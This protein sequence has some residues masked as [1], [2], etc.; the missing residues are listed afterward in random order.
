ML[1]FFDLFYPQ[2][3]TENN[4]TTSIKFID[5]VSLYA[6]VMIK[7]FFPIKHPKITIGGSTDVTRYSD[8]LG[9]GTLALIFCRILPPKD[10]LIPLLPSRIGKTADSARLF[11][12]LCSAC[13][14][15]SVNGDYSPTCTHSEHERCLEGVYT[16]VEL[17][18]A[19]QLGYKIQTVFESY[20]YSMSSKELFSSYV[21]T[22][23]SRKVECSGWPTENVQEREKFVTEF[24]R[25]MGVDLNPENIEDNPGMRQVCKLQ[26][27]SLFG[28]F[29]Q[30]GDRAIYRYCNSFAELK[31]YMMGGM[32]DVKAISEVSETRVLLELQ[33]VEEQVQNAVHTNCTIAAFIC[34]YARL[35]LYEIFEAVGLHNVCYA[36]TD[37][38]CYVQDNSK[39]P[40][41]PFGKMLGDFDHVL[42]EHVD[43]LGFVALGAKSYALQYRDTRTGEMHAKALCKGFTAAM[44]N[45]DKFSYSGFV[46]A[47]KDSATLDFKG[48]DIFRKNILSSTVK[49]V[50][51][52]KQLRPTLN[53]RIFKEDFTSVPFGFSNV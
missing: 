43:I 14:V 47:L 2:Q 16:S 7:F 52:T 11:F 33:P 29:C 40:N 51:M 6:S 38:C 23:F 30:R 22:F 26:L 20:E 21:M 49:C 37:S 27:C 39:P 25:K 50:P 8:G 42:G 9:P 44:R 15:A 10:L 31:D 28:K 48:S 18:K 32:Y 41:I 53:K 36:D 34:S 1:I 17:K 46:R 13:A 35:V 12:P 45:N 5:G 3:I 24:S 19:V 4:R